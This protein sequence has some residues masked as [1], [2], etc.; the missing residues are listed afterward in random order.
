MDN[1]GWREYMFWTKRIF[2]YNSPEYNATIPDTL[3]WRVRHF[4][5]CEPFVEYYLRHPAYSWHPVVGITQQQAKDYSV[6]RSNKVFE[7]ILIKMNKIEWDSLQN[8]DTYFTIEK[9]YNNKFDRII[10]GEKVRYY[11][12]FRLPTLSERKKILQY[13][14]SV[15]RKYF[16]KCNSK[17]CKYCKTN[18]PKF[19]SDINPCVNEWPDLEATV[20]TNDNYSAKKWNSVFNLRGNVSEWSSEINTTFGGGWFNNRDRILQTDTFH[21]YEQ[22]AWTG[23]RNVCEWKQWKE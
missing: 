18:F 1:L 15:D 4:S 11:P 20:N 5:C 23:F 8:K 14:D 2:G 3:V 12:N 10:P 19:Y 13:A 7:N 16:E 6:W 21:I 22:N 9:Y 17:Y